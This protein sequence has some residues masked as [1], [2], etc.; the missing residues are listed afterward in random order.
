[1]HHA[2][3]P[4]SRQPV[5]FSRHHCHPSGAARD[6]GSQRPKAR[7]RSES[8]KGSD[9]CLALKLWNHATRLDGPIPRELGSLLQ[10]L[11]REDTHD[12]FV[13]GLL[14]SVVL[15]EHVEF[16]VRLALG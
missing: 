11:N 15:A 3:N 6:S 10:L 14:E 4:P 8:K 2:G 7:P 16:H 5:P 1:M 13:K 12:C 9:A